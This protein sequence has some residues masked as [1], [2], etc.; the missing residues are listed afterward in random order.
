MFS[1][2]SGFCFNQLLENKLKRD[3]NMHSSEPS[4]DGTPL[5]RPTGPSV[6]HTVCAKSAAQPRSIAP[7]IRLRVW[8]N[9]VH[10]THSLSSLIPSKIKGGFADT[11]VI[12]TLHK[13]EI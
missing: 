1:V 9:D 11:E 3:P 8:S 6:F 2:L 5:H 4:V 7:P 12:L 10:A 13:R